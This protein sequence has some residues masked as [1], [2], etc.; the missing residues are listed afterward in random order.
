MVISSLAEDNE[1][2]LAA[3]RKSNSYKANLNRY[4]KCLWLE[5]AA[6]TL[7]ENSNSEPVVHRRWLAKGRHNLSANEPISVS[8]SGTGEIAADNSKLP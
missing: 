7:T 4:R 8:D 5:S 3:P 1:S 6:G 2:K